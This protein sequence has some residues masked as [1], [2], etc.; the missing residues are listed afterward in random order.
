MLPDTYEITVPDLEQALRSTKLTLLPGDAVIVH[1]GW[2][3]LWGKDNA[4]YMRTN[5]GIGVTAAEWLARQDPMLVGADNPAVNVTPRCRSTGVEPGAPNPARRQ[6]HPSAGEP[7][8]RRP[9]RPAGVEFAMI[10]Q[11]LKIRVAPAR[12]LRLLRCAEPHGRQQ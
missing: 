2:G 4:R 1:T 3:R 11:P 8:A 5:P 12:R 9:C 6:R 7:E 10:V